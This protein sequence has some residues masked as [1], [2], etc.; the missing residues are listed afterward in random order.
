MKIKYK[1]IRIHKNTYE[2]LKRALGR[3]PFN[4]KIAILLEVANV[5]QRTTK[6]I[7]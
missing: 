1:Q 7:N 2:A 6:H 5:K 4:T 3:K